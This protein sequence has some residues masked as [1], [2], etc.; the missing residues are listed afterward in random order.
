MLRTTRI[1]EGGVCVPF[2]STQE[3]GL[4]SVAYARYWRIRTTSTWTGGNYFGVAE[5]ELRKSKDGADLTTPLTTITAYK[6]IGGYEPYKA[7]DNNYGTFY[8]TG[9]NSPGPDGHWLKIDF[10]A[11]VKHPVT[12]IT[13]TV[14]PDGYREDPK[15][16]F[17]EHSGDNI[18]WKKLFHVTDI[19]TWTAGE[20]RVFSLSK[21]RT[22]STYR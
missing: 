19:P 10:G 20:T 21:Y 7:I 2:W 14:R 5:L 12:E 6:Y 11:G 18:T 17:V 3:A 1:R 16:L 22:N 15:N 9:G 4:A 13:L 8:T